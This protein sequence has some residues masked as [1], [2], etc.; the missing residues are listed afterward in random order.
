MDFL[1]SSRW[2]LLSG[3]AVM[4]MLVIPSNGCGQVRLP[5]SISKNAQPTALAESDSEP[6]NQLQQTDKP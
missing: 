6:E 3:L 5:D 1:V 2:A 4:G